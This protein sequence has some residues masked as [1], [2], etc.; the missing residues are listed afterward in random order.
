M[1]KLPK[2]LYSFDALEPYIDAKTMEIHYTKHH[3]TYV[4]K[5][6]AALN[7]CKELQEKSIEE[8]M[9]KLDKIPENIRTAVRNH[10]GGH[11]NHSFFWPLL[12]KN[13]KI[14]VLIAENIEKRLDHRIFLS[15]QVHIEG[16]SL[17]PVFG[18]ENDRGVII[19]DGSNAP[20]LLLFS[21]HSFPPGEG[22]CWLVLRKRQN[23][24]T[25]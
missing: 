24:A 14:K 15:L 7:S 1:F 23:P 12:R 21:Q 17:T 8:L 6:N 19:S 20:A 4:D 22:S 5:L 16:Q 13:V 3:Q 18:Q 2:L 9:K 25:K 11:L 10:G